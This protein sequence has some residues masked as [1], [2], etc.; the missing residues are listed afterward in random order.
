MIEARAVRTNELTFR[1]RLARLQPNLPIIHRT[2]A[3]LRQNLV[4]LTQQCHACRQIRHHHLVLPGMEMARQIYAPGKTL[5]LPIQREVLQAV[6]P[7]VRHCQHRLRTTLVH[8]NP[9]RL[10]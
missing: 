3:Q 8:D 6:V 1:E 2:F 7:P 4:I 5:V 9:V 10:Q